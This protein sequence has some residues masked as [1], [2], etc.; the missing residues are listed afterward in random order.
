MSS[1]NDVM[2]Q[3]PVRIGQVGVVGADDDTDASI[4]MRSHVDPYVYQ[5]L[6][7]QLLV[8]LGQEIHKECI[9]EVRDEMQSELEARRAEL[10]TELSERE[11][12]LEKTLA[13]ACQAVEKAAADL[14]AL[15]DSVQSEAQAMLPALIVDLTHRVLGRAIEAGDYDIDAIIRSALQEL[16]PRGQ[17][18]VRLNPDD[19][20]RS[21]LASQGSEHHAASVV[22]FSRDHNIS[23]GGCVV[24]SSEGR[25][26][27]TIEESLAEIDRTIRD[28][29]EPT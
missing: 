4:D 19:F 11:K 22:Q 2:V 9:R 13:S 25:V 3:L 23:P 15:R 7:K 5:Q 24:E 14:A 28:T 8:E 12:R 26:D 16:P 10:E 18:V 21:E 20:A 29:S 1:R 6:R 27:A 17:I